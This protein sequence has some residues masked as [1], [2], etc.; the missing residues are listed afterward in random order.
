[1][2]IIKIKEYLIIMKIMI[3]MIIMVGEGGIM[4][5]PQEQLEFVIEFHP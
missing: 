5:S 4:N 2:L 1:M 3:S